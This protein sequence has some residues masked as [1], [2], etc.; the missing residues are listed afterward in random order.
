MVNEPPRFAGSIP[1]YYDRCMGPH[2]FEPYAIDVAARVPAGARVLEIACGTGRVTRHLV[3]RGLEVVA[4]D[5]FEPMVAVAR[6]RAPGATF[7]TADAQALPFPDA[8]F[9]AV[10]CQFGLMFLPDKALGVRE[11]RRVLRPGGTALVSV[12]D[13]L[14]NN[15]AS[16]LLHQLARGMFPSAEFMA[17][18]FSMGDAAALPPLFTPFAS[19]TIETVAKTGES[20]D[21]MELATGFTRGNPLWNQLVEN[22]VDAEAFQRTV[23]ER[24]AERFG[25][26]PLRSPLSAHVVT[27]Y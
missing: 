14:A 26:H 4:T 1:D 5:L 25:D 2:L 24:L 20:Q 13:R 9:D 21:A 22:G 19:V 27:A 17:V 11:M 16:E 10:V 15:P 3:A 8:S 6:Q 7:Q 23:A 18:P 12:W